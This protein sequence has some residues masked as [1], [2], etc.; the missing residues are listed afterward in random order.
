V[1]A[2]SGGVTRGATGSVGIHAFHSKEFIGSA[3]FDKASEHF[4]RTAQI[5]RQYLIE[6]RVPTALLDEMIRVPHNKLRTIEVGE[7][8]H[9]GIFGVDP[10]YVQIK[11][12]R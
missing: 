5:V 2:H 9:L 8:E 4:N 10:V 7:M 11:S 12:K 1:I 3:D 6:M